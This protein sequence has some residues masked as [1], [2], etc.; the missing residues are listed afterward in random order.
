[1][2]ALKGI[3]SCAHQDAYVIKRR[4]HTLDDVLSLAYHAANNTD[5]R[6]AAARCYWTMGQC[7]GEGRLP[8]HSYLA[9]SDLFTLSA[10]NTSAPLPKARAFLLATEE[11]LS[12]SPQ[13]GSLSLK[14]LR[15]QVEGAQ[16]T[17][18]AHNDRG[19]LENA[20]ELLKRIETLEK[21]QVSRA[22]TYSFR[23]YS[24]PMD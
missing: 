9:R 20:S 14:N 13:P 8:E 15:A 4:R 23:R 18:A 11:C 5:D 10:Q 2:R 21:S 7:I 17:A 6:E 3:L 24:D 16:R 1:M 22:P 19:L 12:E